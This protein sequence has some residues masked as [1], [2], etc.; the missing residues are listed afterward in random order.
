MST[1]PAT[2]ASN[3]LPRPAWTDPPAVARELFAARKLLRGGGAARRP[4][5][6]PV[7]GAPV[8]LIP[9]LFAGD[10]S[11]QELGGHLAA[12]GFRP[13]VAGI[14]RNVDCS[15]AAAARLTQRLESLADVTGRRVAI[16][17]HSRGGMLARVAA[18]RRPDLVAAV[19]VLGAPHREPLALHPLLLAQTLAVAALGSAGVRGI[20]RY[21]CAFGRCCHQFRRDLSAPAPA[22]HASL[23]VYSRRDGLVDWRAC[24]D[25]HSERVEVHC[26]HCGMAEDPAT[27]HAVASW[28]G[29]VAAV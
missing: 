13:Y 25:S 26:S 29:R 2:S 8:L 10:A 18:H 19:A 15:E 20:L 21:S 12:A 22:G 16:V 14:S 5:E 4:I 27:L 3:W 23:T 6:G 11:M 9:G 17:G 28:L 7:H 24:V 1:H